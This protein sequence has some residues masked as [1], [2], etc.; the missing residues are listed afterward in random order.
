MGKRSP[1]IDEYIAKSTDFAK[2]ILEHLRELVHKACP[3]VEETIKWGMPSFEYKGPLFGFAAFKQHCSFGFWKAKL[4]KDP[5]NYLTP[6][7]NE[8]GEGMGNFG[9]VQNIKDLPPNKAILDFIR[10]AKKLNDDGIKVPK[11]KSVTKALVVPPYFI[12]SL[13]TN[14]KAMAT[15]TAFSI[16]QKREYVTW[17]ADA[18]TEATRDKRMAEALKW[19]AEGKIRNWKY[20]KK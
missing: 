5:G 20:L 14:K 10:Q 8:G 4:L 12:K 3:E 9:K 19:M 6:R 1:R 11:K 17:I 7:A 18:K 15:F 13:K 16:S 2:P